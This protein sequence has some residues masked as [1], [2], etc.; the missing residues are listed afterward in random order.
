MLRATFSHRCAAVVALFALAACAQSQPGQPRPGQPGQGTGVG[1]ATGAVVGG[2]LGNVLSAEGRRSENTA[3]GA[4]VGAALGGGVGYAMDRQ[5][6]DF[7]RELA[8]ER[9]SNDVQIEQL[10]QDVLLLTLDQDVQFAVDSATVQPDFR[11]TLGKVGD[12]LN[13][14]P[15]TE[16]T[17]IGHTDSTGA[18]SYNQTLSERRAEAVRNELAAMGVSSSR[19]STVGR[20][21]SEPRASNDTAAGRAA[22]RRV[23]LVLTEPA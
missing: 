23:E 19:L 5:R 7:E 18:P 2:V 13:R 6:Q 1:A 11:A 21:E 20:G 12:V 22:N 10:R 17:V 3:I 14:Y 4:A 15:G 16:V 8:A 9:A